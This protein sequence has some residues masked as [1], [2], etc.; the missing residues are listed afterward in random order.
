MGR[1]AGSS[2][3]TAGTNWSPVTW[4]GT[5][6]SALYLT[7]V[8]QGGNDEQIKGMIRTYGNPFG[9]PVRNKAA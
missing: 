4:K 1:R 7:N 3:V 5:Q 8:G 6:A 2:Y 9:H